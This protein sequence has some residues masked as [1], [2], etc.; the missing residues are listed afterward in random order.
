VSR[1][2]AGWAALV[3]VAALWTLGSV[4]NVARQVVVEDQSL[5]WLLE[6]PLSLLVSLALGVPAWR[7]L[8]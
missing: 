8:R 2:K 1:S 3:V 7:R 5:L 4:V 6:I